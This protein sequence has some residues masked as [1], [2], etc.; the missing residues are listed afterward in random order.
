GQLLRGEHG[1]EGDGV[2]TPQ[3]RLQLRS[4]AGADGGLV[5]AGEPERPG[6]QQAGREGCGVRRVNEAPSASTR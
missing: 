6:D 4:Q 1:V 2:G 5:L 3:E